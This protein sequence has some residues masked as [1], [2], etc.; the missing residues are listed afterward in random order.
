M[1]NIGA[2][3]TYI[4]DKLYRYRL[5]RDINKIILDKGQR[6]SIYKLEPTDADKYSNTSLTS[7]RK[8]RFEDN[9]KCSNRT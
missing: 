4:K 9:V 8:N 2:I 5:H 6:D 7:E 3:I 1:V